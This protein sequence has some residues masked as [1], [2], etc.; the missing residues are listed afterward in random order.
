MHHYGP[1][2]EHYNTD[3]AFAAVVELISHTNN[4]KPCLSEPTDGRQSVAHC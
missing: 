2:S 1:L 4:G 3:T